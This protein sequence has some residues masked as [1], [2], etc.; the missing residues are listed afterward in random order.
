LRVLG[1]AGV[2]AFLVTAFTPA[3]GLL[4]RRLAVASRPAPA[5]A[6]VV[7]GAS[8]SPDGVLGDASLRRTVEGIRLHRRGLA[9]LLVLLGATTDG[10]PPEAAVREALAREMGI[11]PDAVLA[12][13]D[14][15]TTREEAARVAE[16]L[17]RRRLRRVLLVTDAHHLARAIPLFERHGLTVSPAVADGLSMA[18]RIPG[19][20]LELARRVTQEVLARAYHRLAGYL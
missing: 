9:P 14:A 5:D 6:I 3:A 17:G 20:R 11:T 2:A 10:G 18:T 16:L 8:A 1:A 4:A 15:R 7:L 12:I 19:E 13:G